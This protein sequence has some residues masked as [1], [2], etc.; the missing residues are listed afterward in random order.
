[1]SREEPTLLL[2]LRDMIGREVWGR[3]T[4]ARGEA[5]GKEE[6]EAG[7]GKGGAARC[8]CVEG[9]DPFGGVWSKALRVCGKAPGVCVLLESRN[10]QQ[11]L[12]R[13]LLVLTII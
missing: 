8:V 12:R 2:D 10:E 13:D 5:R 3:M 1:M 7:E 9:Q 6:R 11:I 4:R